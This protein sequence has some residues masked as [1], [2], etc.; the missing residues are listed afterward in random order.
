MPLPRAQPHGPQPGRSR[1]ARRTAMGWNQQRLTHGGAEDHA[2][3]TKRVRGRVWPRSAAPQPPRGGD[4]PS[5]FPFAPAQAW[6]RMLSEKDWFGRSLGDANR[7]LGHGDPRSGLALLL[8]AYQLRASERLAFRDPRHVELRGTDLPLRS[9]LQL[10]A[11]EPCVGPDCVRSEVRR[12]RRFARSRSRRARL[13]VR[14]HRRH[15]PQPAA[16][17]RAVQRRCVPFRASR[18]N[19]NL[20]RGPQR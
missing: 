2:L 20:R 11:R 13:R 1:T 9:E 12:S 4:Q 5:R 17:R 18:T 14:G 16:H 19:R 6:T 3:F 7:S 8:D 10:R 15:R